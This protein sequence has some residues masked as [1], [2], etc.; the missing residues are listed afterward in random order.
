[1]NTSPYPDLQQTAD[2]QE[3]DFFSLNWSSFPWSPWVPF[4]ATKEEFRQIPREPGLYRIRPIG[5]DFLMYIGETRRTAHERLNELRHTLKRTDLMPWNDPITEAPALW[6]WKDA[7][8]F[9]YECSAAPLD[10]SLG[11]RRGMES[12]LLY[13]YRLEYGESTLCN[14]GRFHP[15]YRKSTNR[16]ENRRGGRLADD[17]KDNPAGGP[18]VPS[19]PSV[20]KP[21]DADWMGLAWSGKKPLDEET[22]SSVPTEAG[23]YL[24]FERDTRDLVSIGQSADYAKRL[25]SHA[26]K[27]LEGNDLM[28]SWYSPEKPLLPHN[29]KEWENDLI[30]NYFDIYR[31]A[32]KYQFG[33]RDY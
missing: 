28:V 33:N 21:G 25:M 2:L 9:E 5:K 30:G 10:A 27:F 13:R 12:Y 3:R 32:P 22:I 15:R 17:H 29:L 23:L 8:G 18:G 11:G 26:M 7:E 1:M 16:K 14:F 19:L 6:A 31:R 4:T 20:G 24:L